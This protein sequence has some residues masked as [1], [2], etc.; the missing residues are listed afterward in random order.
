ML[1]IWMTPTA[2]F[3]FAGNLASQEFLLFNTIGT[4]Q[5][6]TGAAPISGLPPRA[7]IHY[8]LGNLYSNQVSR[9]LPFGMFTSA[10]LRGPR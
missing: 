7:S 2:K 8:Y 9:T 4:L 5:A 3:A 1:N 6:S 10:M